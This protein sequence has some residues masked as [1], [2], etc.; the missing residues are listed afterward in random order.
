MIKIGR[1]D[2]RE[3]RILL[4]IF[5]AMVDGRGWEFQ[6][7]KEEDAHS[8]LKDGRGFGVLSMIAG[9]LTG[10]TRWHSAHSKKWDFT[11]A[12]YSLM[13]FCLP[14]EYQTSP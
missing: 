11:R 9:I 1:L 5:T 12:V 2:R 13:S 7:Q 10:D 8:P 14:S 3:A 4:H 6:H